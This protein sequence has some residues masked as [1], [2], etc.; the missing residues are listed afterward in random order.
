MRQFAP[1]LSWRKVSS[2]WPERCQRTDSGVR[3]QPPHHRTLRHFIFQ[4]S[5]Q[6]LDLRRQL[7]EY[8]DRVLA[9]SPSALYLASITAVQ[10]MSDFCL[11]ASPR[12]CH[13]QLGQKD[14]KL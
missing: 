13:F 6:F 3:H 12:P 1:P 5:R 7:V 4:W 10:P 8:V 11:A 14:V 9:H 2:L